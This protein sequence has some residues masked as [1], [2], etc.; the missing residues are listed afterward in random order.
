MNRDAV[1][2]DATGFYVFVNKKNSG[3]HML[4]FIYVK[5]AKQSYNDPSTSYINI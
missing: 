4:R 5:R 3:I 1:E 2:A